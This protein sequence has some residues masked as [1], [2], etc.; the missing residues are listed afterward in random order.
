MTLQRAISAY[1]SMNMSSQVQTQP[2]RHLQP[3]SPSYSPLHSPCHVQPAPIYAVLQPG[4]SDDSPRHFRELIHARFSE[5][6]A[7]LPPR[8]EPDRGLVTDIGDTIIHLQTMVARIAEDLIDDNRIKQRV[9][10]LLSQ[11][12]AAHLSD[13]TTFENA[14]KSHKA[15]KD[16]RASLL[17]NLQEVTHIWNQA[18]GKQ[19][20][21]PPRPPP[22]PAPAAVPAPVPA[23]V[24]PAA[25]APAP[26]PAP[27]ST[28][29]EHPTSPSSVLSGS[30]RTA[31]STGDVGGSHQR[32]YSDT[33]AVVKQS[34]E[35]SAVR[36]PVS[37]SM[38][39]KPGA[40]LPPD[41][42]DLDDIDLAQLRNRGK[43][44]YRCS[45]GKSCT[46]GGVD[47][48]GNIVIFERNCMFRQ[49]MDKHKK[50][51]K[52]PIP[53]CQNKDGFARK[54][55]LE[56]HIKNVRHENIP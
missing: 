37:P 23:P 26:A 38:N 27:G 9:N 17:E 33:S 53:G 15:L 54:D 16:M 46:K 24:P 11:D 35:T 34:P 50:P 39:S 31:L 30:S 20:P 45:Y 22:A 12:S 19:P 48:H 25:P 49:H 3:R 51:F 6:L 13:L 52:C 10:G 32:A 44:V 5:A 21:P 41:P 7:T 2:R 42:M 8:Q 47:R 18:P 28:F 43:G 4:S 40:S 55:Q 29:S 14:H 36:F 56:R 1:P